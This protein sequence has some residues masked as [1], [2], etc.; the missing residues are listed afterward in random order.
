MKKLQKVLLALAAT[1]TV[2]SSV[3]FAEDNSF[4]LT[5]GGGLFMGQK[6][7]SNYKLDTFSENDVKYKN[8]AL[9][10][11]ILL[12]VG[13]YVMD[14]VHVEA[15]YVKPFF[16]KSKNTI[17][18][19]ID[20]TE[21]EKA[22]DKVTNVTPS[23]NALQLR[24][25]YDAFDI[26]DM[27]K[28]YFGAGLGWSNVKAKVTNFKGIEEKAKAKNTLS[29][30]VGLGASFDLTEGVKVAAEYN[31]QDFGQYKVKGAPKVSLNG[32]AV[33]AKLVFSI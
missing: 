20:A 11:E 33:L 22:K 25:Y 2:L 32:H 29:W 21:T 10:G 1:S 4:Y 27:G 16:G 7:A 14:N 24:A 3:S 23:V 19:G 5:A 30:T 6:L 17:V 28:A 12:G 26:A 18:D 9:G 8:P 13:Y 31:Y 15:L